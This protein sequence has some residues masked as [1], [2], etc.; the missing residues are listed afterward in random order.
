MPSCEWQAAGRATRAC[1]P[2]LL[3]CSRVR[4]RRRRRPQDLA[5]GKEQMSPI[6][7]T[8]GDVVW[9]ND[10]ATLFYVVKDHLDRRESAAWLRCVT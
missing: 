8:S 5:S 3:S 10:N 7:M 6:P 1:L 4:R 9:A 2:P